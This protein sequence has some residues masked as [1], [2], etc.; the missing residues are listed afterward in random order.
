MIGKFQQCKVTESD[1]KGDFRVFRKSLYDLCT[2]LH[3]YLQKQQ[4]RL[5]GPISV[6]VQVAYYISVEGAVGKLQ[7]LLIFLMHQFWI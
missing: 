2:K 1:W 7:M 3:P 4:N 6:E 5:R